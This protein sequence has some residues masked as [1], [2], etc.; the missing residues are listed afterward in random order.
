MN[1]PLRKRTKFERLQQLPKFWKK[2]WKISK[3]AK[4]KDRISLLWIHTTIIMKD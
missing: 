2:T 4:L 1:I 3:G